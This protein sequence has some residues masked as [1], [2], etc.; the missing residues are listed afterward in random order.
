MGTAVEGIA[1]LIHI[2]NRLAAG[3]GK[4]FGMVFENLGN[5]ADFI[6]RPVRRFHDI[7]QRLVHLLADG[8]QFFLGPFAGGAKIS[9]A[10]VHY[11]ADVQHHLG[12]ARRDLHQ[13]VCPAVQQPGHIFDLAGGLGRG[14]VQSLGAVVNH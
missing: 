13:P 2:G 9:R 8:T 7:G 4:V 11:P 6:Y 14:L 5:G 1:G 12:R 3:L 10:L